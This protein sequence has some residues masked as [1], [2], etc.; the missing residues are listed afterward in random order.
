[1]IYIH[2]VFQNKINLSGFSTFVA[3]LYHPLAGEGKEKQYHERFKKDED[4][5]QSVVV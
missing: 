1:M 5:A 3:A 2:S 4:K